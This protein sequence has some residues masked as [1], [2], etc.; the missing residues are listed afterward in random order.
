[1]STA[2][3]ALPFGA[4]P[5]SETAPAPSSR[6]VGKREADV[7]HPQN[8][9]IAQFNSFS[10]L[11]ALKKKLKTNKKAKLLEFRVGGDSRLPGRGSLQPVRVGPPRSQR[12]KGQM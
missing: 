10:T 3:R 6:S 12:V 7:P 2:R 9:N 11:V 8:S 5:A 1:M 4:S